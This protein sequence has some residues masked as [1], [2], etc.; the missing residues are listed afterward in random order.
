MWKTIMTYLK[1][2]Q[3]DKYE[4][5]ERALQEAKA[6]HPIWPE[7]KNKQALIMLEEAGEVAKAVLQWQDEGQPS[8]NIVQELRQTAAMC[9]RMLEHL[10]CTIEVHRHDIP[11]VEVLYMD[12]VYAELD[13]KDVYEALVKKVGYSDNIEIRTWLEIF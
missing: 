6:K 11:D 2:K 7:D 4:P 8:S 1:K 13:Y 3:M 5:I 12:K 9:M 10:G